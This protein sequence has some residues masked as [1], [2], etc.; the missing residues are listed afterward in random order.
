MVG[1]WMVGELVGGWVNDGLD[2]GSWWGH[3]E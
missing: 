2:D 3:T 1:R